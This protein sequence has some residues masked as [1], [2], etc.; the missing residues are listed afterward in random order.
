VRLALLLGLLLLGWATP[1]ASAQEEQAEGC[2]A[3]VL[4]MQ[5]APSAYGPG[6][7]MNLLFAIENR[8][9]APVDT[10]KATVST[11]TPAG[12]TATPSQ[13]ELTLGPGA[14]SWDVLALAAPHRG[15]G[16]PRGNVTL[17]VT[18][19]C[20]SG[21]VQTS[22][23]ST[24]VFPVEVQSF[25][26]PWPLV[27]AGFL[28]LA[29]GVVVLGIRR[30]RRGVAL[31]C[32]TPERLVA[33]GKSAKFELIVENRRG[34]PQRLHFL[35]IGVPE[36]WQVHLAL[37]DVEL[38]PGEEKN[39]WALLKAPPSAQPGDEAQVTL[40]L[41]GRDTAR[42]GAATTVRARVSGA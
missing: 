20:T 34:K 25:Q 2:R 27:L 18:F 7:T 19:V 13:R 1:S 21:D 15:T 11:T 37:D 12:W 30:L 16:E 17:L 29:G 38:E 3:P 31:S 41:V 35:A 40:R 26:A 6:T 5:D 10:T 8:N 23:S 39:L 22:A 28:L 14:V 24:L 9:I 33:P 32:K 4:S 42:E 36:G